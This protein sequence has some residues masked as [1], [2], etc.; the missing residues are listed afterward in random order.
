MINRFA[1]FTSRLSVALT[2]LFTVSACGGGGGGGFIPKDDD[3]NPVEDL[4]AITTTALPSAI[5]GVQYTALVEASG[6]I[7]P[8]SWNLVDDGG[9]M[10]G[11]HKKEL[12][13]RIS[14]LTTHA[15]GVLRLR[16][17]DD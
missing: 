12:P 10:I 9:T 2:I 8:Y 14:E 7:E 1:T 17:H 15:F 13:H 11:R 6:G 5:E 16:R 3:G 4:P